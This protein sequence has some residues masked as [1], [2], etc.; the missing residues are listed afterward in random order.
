MISFRSKVLAVACAVA[1]TATVAVAGLTAASASP[2]PR[3][4]WTGIEHF[5]LMTT[6]ATSSKESIIAIGGVF[7]AGGVDYQGNKVDR[8]VFPGGTFKIRH[9]SGKGTQNFNPKTCLNVISLH[10]TYSLG[11]GTGK[12][13]GISGHGRYQLSILFVAARN[14]KGKCSQTKPPA[15]YQQIIK[16]HGPAKL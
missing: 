3:P 16:A 15:A 7:T 5:Q 11:H 12:Y 6:S 4:S 1:A 8:V 9:S 13:A 14:S 10:G 2:A